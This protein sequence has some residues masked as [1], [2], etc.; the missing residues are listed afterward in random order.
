M[1]IC[2]SLQICSKATP[3]TGT[4]LVLS[5]SV[6]NPVSANFVNGNF[7][8]INKIDAS[9]VQNAVL[10]LNGGECPRFIINSTIIGSCVARQAME[11]LFSQVHTLIV[12]GVSLKLQNSTVFQ[13]QGDISELIIVDSNIQSVRALVQKVAIM[14][15]NVMFQDSNFNVINKVE[16][17]NIKIIG[18]LF[19]YSL[20]YIIKNSNISVF[21]VSMGYM[22]QEVRMVTN[23]N[24]TIVGHIVLNSTEGDGKVLYKSP[25]QHV[26][27]SKI[28]LKYT[29]FVKDVSLDQ[30]SFNFGEDSDAD[31]IQR[32]FSFVS[33]SQKEAKLTFDFKFNASKSALRFST[34]TEALSC[35]L[36]GATA[37]YYITGSFIGQCSRGTPMIFPE[38]GNLIIEFDLN[39]P[40]TLDSDQICSI[41][42]VFDKICQKQVI[43]SYGFMLSIDPLQC[44]TSPYT[45]QLILTVISFLLVLVLLVLLILLLCC[46][47]KIAIF[48]QHH[49]QDQPDPPKILPVVHLNLDQSA[50]STSGSRLIQSRASTRNESH[51][52]L[53]PTG[54]YGA[55]FVPKPRVKFNRVEINSDDEDAPMDYLK[56]MNEQM[57]IKNETVK[58][59]YQGE[60]LLDDDNLLKYMTKN[61]GV[62]RQK[63]EMEEE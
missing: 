25:F 59:L 7:H 28:M 18:N 21:F 15:S 5:E 51:Q 56:L 62:V 32:N 24:I 6:T 22:Q 4:A 49:V 10:R 27:S 46:R 29:L 50:T 48:H 26:E 19:D 60:E 36:N 35:S 11:V 43:C 44:V 1:L 63:T 16:T 53:A 14:N 31:N 8:Q 12:E 3:C 41:D 33:A 45:L 20:I 57:N 39:L 55:N 9:R 58:T 47:E 2:L 40:F 54:I 34:E 30:V 37:P 38:H 17:S 13:I 52:K 61:K 42:E 23:S